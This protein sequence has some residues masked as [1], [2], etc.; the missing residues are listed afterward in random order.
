MVRPADT[1]QAFASGRRA[2]RVLLAGSGPVVGWGVGSHDLAL[3]GA[4]ARALAST[5]GRGAVVDVLPHPSAGVRRLH[6]MLATVEL[7][8]YDAVVLSAAV[9]DATRLAAPE[10]WSRRLR[11]LLREVEARGARTVVWLGAQPIR[12]TPAHHST[13]R[14]IARDHADRLNRVAETVCREEGAV[15]VRL[16]QAPDPDD[17][18]HRSPADYLFWA[19]HIADAFAPVAGSASGRSSGLM[20]NDAGRADAIGRLRLPPRGANRRLNRLVET[21][22]RALGAEI[23]MIC[24]LDDRAERPIASIGV[25]VDE[26]PIEQ[27]TCVHTIQAADGMVV[28]DALKDPRFAGSPFATGPA[29]LRFYAGYPVEAPD[30]TRIGAICVFDRTERDPS[31]AETDLDVLRELALLAQRELFLLQEE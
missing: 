26:I 4:L 9:A 15:F 25:T 24:V 5:T 1:P 13:S 28:A 17:S 8:R 11:H 23:A 21:A 22:H 7:A 10:R 20:R 29:H 30:G 19:R 12:S 27:S 16:P 6:A 2:M 31:E 18:R 3:P 14:R